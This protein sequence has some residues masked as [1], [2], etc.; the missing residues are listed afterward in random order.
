MLSL[1]LYTALVV[2]DVI[3]AIVLFVVAYTQRKVKNSLI[4]GC[5]FGIVALMNAMAIMGGIL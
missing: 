3:F 2:I 1:F 4:T 5:V